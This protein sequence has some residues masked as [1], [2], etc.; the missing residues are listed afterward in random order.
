MCCAKVAPKM[1]Y[2]CSKDA[3]L[4]RA[5]I[6]TNGRYRKRNRYRKKERKKECV[7]GGN[8]HASFWGFPLLSPTGTWQYRLLLVLL[9]ATGCR[10][11]A[12]V[13]LDSKYCVLQVQ[14][15]TFLACKLQKMIG[16]SLPKLQNLIR[17]IPYK[18]QNL[19]IFALPKLQN[20]I[21]LRGSKV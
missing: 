3:P 7:A 15:Q 19:I 12:V 9:M 4:P 14:S 5:I 20:S 16:F 1:F 11:A 6:S 21:D 2:S 18:L 10:Q 8:R 17:L 13:F